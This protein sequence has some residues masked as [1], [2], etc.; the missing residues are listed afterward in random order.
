M[1]DDEVCVA[2]TLSRNNLFSYRSLHSLSIYPRAVYE[3]SD[4]LPLLSYS[5]YTS[6]LILLIIL[7]VSSL[8]KSD[9][10]L[11]LLLPLDLIESPRLLLDDLD[12]FEFLLLRALRLSRLSLLS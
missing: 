5:L 12:F 4:L 6:S 3:I 9:A 1:C 2:I 8:Y 10:W 11:I 7:L